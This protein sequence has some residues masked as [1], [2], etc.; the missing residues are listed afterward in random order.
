LFI[1]VF[2]LETTGAYVVRE[3]R[4]RTEN[5]KGRLT[6]WR[7]PKASRPPNKGCQSVKRPVWSL[8]QALRPVRGHGHLSA[9]ASSSPAAATVQLP[10]L[11]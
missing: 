11:A 10:S 8:S 2:E 6:F 4:P 5:L 1:P 3:R 9:N 7:F